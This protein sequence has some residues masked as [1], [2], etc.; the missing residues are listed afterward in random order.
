MLTAR[1]R[2]MQH[3]F[4]MYLFVRSNID[5]FQGT[6][7]HSPCNR[8]CHMSY[9][10]VWLADQRESKG[11]SGNRIRREMT[12][13]PSASTLYGFPRLTIARLYA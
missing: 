2:V 8:L 7:S 12:D 10:I 5:N 6:S 1:Y 13:C 9:D 11:R 4:M 3:N